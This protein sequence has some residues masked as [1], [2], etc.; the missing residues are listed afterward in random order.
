MKRQIRRSV[1]ETNSSSVHSLTMCTQSDYD[2]WKNE[3]LIYDYWDNKLIST[4]ELDDDYEEDPYDYCY[5]CSGYGDD[6]YVDEDGE[7]VCRCPECP[8][9][10]NSWDD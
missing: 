3:E 7:L 9:N 8:M 10:P 4:D 5:E 2:R 6:Y 1:F